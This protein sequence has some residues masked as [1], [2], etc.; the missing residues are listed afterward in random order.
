MHFGVRPYIFQKLQGQVFDFDTQIKNQRPDPW[1]LNHSFVTAYRLVIDMYGK[2]RI[3]VVRR[4]VIYQPKKRTKGF[5][6]SVRSSS[7]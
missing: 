6:P 7:S 3:T 2:I 5:N 4:A 1:D